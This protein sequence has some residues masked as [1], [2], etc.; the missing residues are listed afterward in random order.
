MLTI[1]LYLSVNEKWFSWSDN[2]AYQKQFAKS[3][4][5]NQGKI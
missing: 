5:Q 3:I 1:M 2:Y 4:L